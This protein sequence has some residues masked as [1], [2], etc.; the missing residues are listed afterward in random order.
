[1]FPNKEFNVRESEIVKPDLS[2]ITNI[3]NAHIENFKSLQDIAK[4]P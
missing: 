3:S 1:M 4:T 2:L